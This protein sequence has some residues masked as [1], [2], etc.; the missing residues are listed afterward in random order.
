MRARARYGLTATCLSLLALAAAPAAQAAAP[1][2]TT[3]AA[4][5]V[6]ATHAQLHGTL[7]PEG[8]ASVY[9][10]QYG[11]ADCASSS[12]ASVPADEEGPPPS[13]EAGKG[14]ESFLVSQFLPG[15]EPET[16]YHFRILAK[17]ASGTTPGL[18]ET[19][20]TPAAPGPGEACANEALREEQHATFLPD[21]RAYEM[22]SPA[23]KNGNDVF[24]DNNR[25]RAAADGSAVGFFSLGAFAD[26]I[27]T[28]ITTEYVSERSAGGWTTHAVTPA[29]ASTSYGEVF[30]LIDSF[31]V[32]D[33]IQDLG[34]GTF[35][36][37][38]PLTADPNVAKVQNLYLRT[39]LRSAGAGSY[40]LLTACPYCEEALDRELPAPT[41]QNQTKEQRPWLAG[42]SPDGTHAS[43]E[44]RFK[45]SKDATALS[46]PKVYEWDE[47]TV[48]L[49]GRVPSG[50]A[51]EC[52]DSGVPACIAS[53]ASIA[54]QSAGAT[55]PELRVPHGVSDG[56]DGHSRVFFTRPTQ[57][58]ST[59]LEVSAWYGQLFVREDG[60]RTIQLNAN[61]RT[62]A[63]SYAAAE[64]QDAS[65]D[66]TRAFF[67]TEQSLTDDAPEA[68]NKLYMWS[69]AP[70]DAEEHHLTYVTDGVKFVIGTGGSGHYVYFIASG[71]SIPGTPALNGNDAGIYLWHDGALSYVG[72]APVAGSRNS[73]NVAYGG[74]TQARLSAD[75]RY[76][77]FGTPEGNGLL[78]YDQAGCGQFHNQPCRELYLYDAASSSP[79]EPDLRC[80]SCN[81]AGALPTGEATVSVHGNYSGAQSAT[82]RAIALAEGPDGHLRALFSTADAL[83]PRDTNGVSDAYSYD[84][85]TEE[86]HLLSSG[87]DS[88]ESWLMDASTDGSNAFV[89]TAQRLVGWDHDGSWD[90]YD[91]RTGGGFPEP[92]PAS[93]PC[94]G[95]TC[96]DPA[97]SPPGP[98]A[99]GSTL[100]TP[101]N[102]P[103]KRPPCPKGTKAKKVK[104]KTRCVKHHKHHRRAGA[105]HGGSK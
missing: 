17:N 69:A 104:G 91:V 102:P 47:G 40:Q 14:T 32:G 34:A 46:N 23:E 20:T 92:P 31:Y 60:H 37:T 87:T 43:F 11:P 16:T 88:H 73:L 36:A 42:L 10:F 82:H 19:F 5:H 101:G 39:D 38:G 96:P 6:A 83:V 76:L 30:S 33:F 67:T 22:V 74:P 85:T 79:S 68:G 59:A 94:Q 2:V 77:L 99:V 65:P 89:L 72:P 41:T 55:K 8:E 86:A 12:C 45:L 70:V 26:A 25:T 15:L 90:L 13:E 103:V 27:G 48:R 52:D 18:D 62:V 56:S 57:P 66:G 21:C 78:G 9:W 54:G 84:V 105:K 50:G 1:A 4:T 3:K 97:A 100:V 81:P 35:Y 29:L 61:E 95:E 53:T 64:Y 7:D 49:A 98:A 75:G 28:G 51:S 93:E 58:T 71:Q 44:S 80:L 24:P 63:A